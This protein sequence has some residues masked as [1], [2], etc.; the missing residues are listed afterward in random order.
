MADEAKEEEPK[1]ASGTRRGGSR[2][3]SKNAVN[4]GDRG[5]TGQ[6]DEKPGYVFHVDDLSKRI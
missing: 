5:E 1:S 3:A 6:C 4:S 2:I